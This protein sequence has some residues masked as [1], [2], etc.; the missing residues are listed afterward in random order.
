MHLP[1]NI[2]GLRFHNLA[3]P[4]EI[5]SNLATKGPS[6]AHEPQTMQESGFAYYV[7]VSN[8]DSS[9]DEGDEDDR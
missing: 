5:K 4:Y 3:T 2:Q 6:E 8:V 9:D 1:S 7:C